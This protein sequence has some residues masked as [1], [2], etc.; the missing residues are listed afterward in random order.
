MLFVQKSNAEIADMIINYGFSLTS[1]RSTEIKNMISTKV[2]NTGSTHFAFAFSILSQAG[3]LALSDG[4]DIINMLLA[5]DIEAFSKTLRN[6]CRFNLFRNEKIENIQH[7]FGLLIKH[8]DI[9]SFNLAIERLVLNQHSLLNGNHSIF[10]LNSLLEH[11]SP[12]RL[13]LALIFLEDYALFSAENVRIM[14]DYQNVIL[15]INELRNLFQR[16][17]AP[18][19]RQEILLGAVASRKLIDYI[20]EII[21]LYESH[22]LDV[23]N[24]RNAVNIPDLKDDLVIFRKMCPSNSFFSVTSPSTYSMASS[25]ASADSPLGSL[26]DLLALCNQS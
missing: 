5:I 1:P 15:L 17:I 11:D 18:N 10:I 26:S 21:C 2:A 14:S 9:S 7:F 8:P 25:T 3:M 19:F 12:D 6:I 22:K 13:S 4:Y 16:P 23:S 24:I 20:A